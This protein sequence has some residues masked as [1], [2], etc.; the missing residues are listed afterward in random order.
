MKG[1]KANRKSSI[2]P[3]K[4]TKY[5]SLGG[6]VVFAKPAVEKLVTLLEGG[7]AEGLGGKRIS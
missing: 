1:R 4:K 6:W 5:S 3:K 2:K 7:V